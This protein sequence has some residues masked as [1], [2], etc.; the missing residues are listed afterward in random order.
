MIRALFMPR[1]VCLVTLL[2]L[3]VSSRDAE[4]T[5]TFSGRI[6]DVKGHPVSGLTLIHSPHETHQRSCHY[7]YGR[8]YYT[9][10]GL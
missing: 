2:F 5:N 7:E 6:V 10:L 3:T 1:L 4:A 9:I 8:R